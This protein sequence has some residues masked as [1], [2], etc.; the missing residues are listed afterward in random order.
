MWMGLAAAAIVT[1]GVVG[2][3]ATM[4]TTGPAEA[5]L[6][7]GAKQSGVRLRLDGK[8]V[9]TL[10]LEVK[11]IRPGE[12]ALEFSVDDH[13]A[14]ETMQVS[15]APNETRE[16]AAV[17]LK[18]VRGI[19]SF[20]VRTEGATLA[21]W[22]GDQRRILSDPSRPIEVDTSRPAS[23]EISKPGYQT[24]RE[25]LIFEEDAK[26]TF[27]VQVGPRESSA[28]AVAEAKPRRDNRV[29][30]LDAPALP[31]RSSIAREPRPRVERESPPVKAEAAPRPEPA[32]KTVETAGG[33]CSF[34]FN[35][36]PPSNVVLDGRPLGQTP[37]MGVPVPPGTHN[38]MFVNGDDTKRVPVACKGGEKKTVAIRF[39]Q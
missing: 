27:V 32:D 10:P 23:L 31:P 20:D 16:L 38:A 35:S 24:V 13:Y 39:S 29:A 33:N 22:S 14:T 7:A 34:N 9:G 21:L 15:L 25:P 26:K 11:N 36:L 4:K 19:A 18:V 30:S 1:V 3:A 28:V 17:F 6:K 5:T 37:K 12:H 8:E 2:I